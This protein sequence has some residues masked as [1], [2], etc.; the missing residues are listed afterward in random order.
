[1]QAGLIEITMMAKFEIEKFNGSNFSLWKLK[2]KAILRKDNCLASI[3]DRTEGISDE[4]WN[5]MD[6]NV[7]A[8]LHLALA[9]S[10]LSSVAEKK[11]AKGIWDVLIKL[12]E[13]KSLHNRIF[14]KR[15]LYTLR[16]SESTFV[17]N[18]INTFNTM[19]AQ[20]TSTNFTI[21]ENE[22]AELLLQSLSDSYDPLVVNLTNNNVTDR[23]YFDDVAGAILEEDPGV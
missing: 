13:V 14:L 9:D 5:E 19:F 20:L 4:K 21:A 8:N 17:I 16:M 23:L 18:H 1:M 12:Y 10:V 3:E 15:R 2:I 11:T 7:V 22:R 6:N